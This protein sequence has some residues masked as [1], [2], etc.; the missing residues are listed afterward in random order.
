MTQC[1]CI[2]MAHNIYDEFRFSG[3]GDE[4]LWS[5][6]Y[7]QMPHCIVRCTCMTMSLIIPDR[8]TKYWYQKIISDFIATYQRPCCLNMMMYPDSLASETRPYDPQ[9]WHHCLHHRP[10]GWGQLYHHDWTVWYLYLLLDALATQISAVLNR[11][12]YEYDSF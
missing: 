10:P 1:N 9:P 6:A 7:D 11:S 2:A 3:F 12:V 4:T 5:S 8:N